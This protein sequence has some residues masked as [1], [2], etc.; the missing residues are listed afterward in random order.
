[1]NAKAIVVIA[2]LWI[3]SLVG[4]GLWAQG[5]QRPWTMKGGPPIGSVITG[6]NIGFQRVDQPDHSDGS[7]RGWWMVKIDGQWRTTAQPVR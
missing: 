2:T 7:I 3:V 5:N 1:M 4:V 6:E